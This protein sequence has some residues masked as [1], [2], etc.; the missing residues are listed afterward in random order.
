LTKDKEQLLPKILVNSVPKSGTHLLIQMILGIPGMKITPTW[1]YPTTF[2]TLKDMKPA[3]VGPAHLDYSPEHARQLEEWGVKVVFISRDLRD[4]AVSL[5]HFVMEN[6]WNSHPLNPYLKSLP[7]HEERLLTVIR[8]VTLSEQDA[9]QYGIKSWPGIHEFTHRRYSWLDAPSSNVCCVTFEDLVRDQQSQ[10]RGIM[11]MINFLWDDLQ[12]Q[13][14]TKLQLLQLIK[15][16]ID[17][18]SSGTFRKG[19]IGN[20][21]DEFTEPTKKA[22]K[23]VAGNILIQLGYEKDLNW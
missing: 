2:G 5:V 10:N 7:T 23:D 21:K 15:Q 9:S 11:K 12:Y 16:N 13:S 19:T 22:F 18:K 6:R 8:G 20:W 4:I 3:Q 17:P 1:Y 14:F